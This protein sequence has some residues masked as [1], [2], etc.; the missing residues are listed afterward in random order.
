MYVRKIGVKGQSLDDFF[1]SIQILKNFGIQTPSYSIVSGEVIM[2]YVSKVDGMSLDITR[3]PVLPYHDNIDVGKVA[4]QYFEIGLNLA[5]YFRSQLHFP[6]AFYGDLTPRQFMLTE[7]G[8]LM[9]DLSMDVVRTNSHDFA[10]LIRQQFNSM[11]KEYK[12]IWKVIR[13]GPG[14]DELYE[15]VLDTMHETFIYSQ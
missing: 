9:V 6:E 8:P 3:N 2:A 7:K 10:S 15:K 12:E 11:A 1:R 5:H 13:R 14:Y 4:S